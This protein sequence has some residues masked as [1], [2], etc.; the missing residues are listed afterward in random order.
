MSENAQ[1]E[2]PADI[3]RIDEVGS[4]IDDLERLY[5]DGEIEGILQ[6]HA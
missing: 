5:E 6:K 2:K 1:Q 4:L 3:T